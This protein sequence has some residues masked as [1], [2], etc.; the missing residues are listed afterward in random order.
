M[1]RAER[2]VPIEREIER[3]GIQLRRSSK[4]WVGPCAAALEKMAQPAGRAIEINHQSKRTG[5]HPV[6]DK[7]N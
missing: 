1:A 7:A 3:R 4:E 6:L 5:R 2:D